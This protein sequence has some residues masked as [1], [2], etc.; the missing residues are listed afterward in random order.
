MIVWFAGMFSTKPTAR[1]SSNSSRL[2][3]AFPLLVFFLLIQ[4]HIIP[5][6]WLNLH[7]W[8]QTRA[9][10]AAGLAVTLVGCG[11]AIWARVTLGRNW[12]GLP[13]VRQEHELIVRGPYRLV[14]HPIYSGLLLAVAG[15]AIAYDNPVWL[16]C[17]VALTLS[18]VVK[19]RQEEQ[20]M[21][22]TFP[23][24]YPEYRRQVKALIPFVL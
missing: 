12:S 21:N 15:S 18:Y 24:A 23:E 6:R 19:M 13:K 10:Q 4:F 5:A 3:F 1:N 22:E 8:P 14:R 9:M 2:T 17:L 7:L 11:F 20:L 16:I